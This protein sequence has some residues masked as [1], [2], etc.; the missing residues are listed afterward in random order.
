MTYLKTYVVIR[1]VFGYL[2]AF[3][4]LSCRHRQGPY[5]S[6]IPTGSS[7]PIYLDSNGSGHFSLDNSEAHVPKSPATPDAR[8][9]VSL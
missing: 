7:S 3:E 8:F 6:S 1:V 9:A 5:G 4:K 2:I